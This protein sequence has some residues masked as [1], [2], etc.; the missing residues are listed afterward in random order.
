M[1]SSSAAPGSS[2]SQTPADKPKRSIG[3]A[4]CTGAA[5]AA[6]QSPNAH[7][8]GLRTA[9]IATTALYQSARRRAVNLIT[10]TR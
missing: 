5:P 2:T 4:A 3:L 10:A 8:P 7:H 6:S 9:T 1:P